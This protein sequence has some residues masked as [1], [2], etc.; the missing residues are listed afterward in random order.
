MTEKQNIGHQHCSH[1]K[2]REIKSQ[3]GSTKL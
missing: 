3:S 1:F 2:R